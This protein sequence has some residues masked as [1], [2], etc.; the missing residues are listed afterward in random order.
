[1]SLSKAT[2]TNPASNA[3]A[4][5]LGNPWKN[6]LSAVSNFVLKRANLKA[7]LTQ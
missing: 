1:M 2:Q 7:A 5:G 3:A 6:R 4:A